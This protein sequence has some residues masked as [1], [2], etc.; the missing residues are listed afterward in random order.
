MELKESM[1]HTEHIAKKKNLILNGVKDYPKTGVEMEKI[2][3]TLFQ[4]M[5]R[6]DSHLENLVG[7]GD[8]QI[9][10]VIQLGKHTGK[11]N[12]PILVTFVMQ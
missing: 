1:L 11:I 9:D 7:Q 12:R 8:M 2:V 5:F 4:T 3:K 6:E 10:M